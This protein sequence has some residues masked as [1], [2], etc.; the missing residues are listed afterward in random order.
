[1]YIL[2]QSIIIY[3]PYLI[4]PLFNKGEI[5]KINIIHEKGDFSEQK[6]VTKKL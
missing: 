1:M 2:M 5:S 6:R 3:Y 4:F